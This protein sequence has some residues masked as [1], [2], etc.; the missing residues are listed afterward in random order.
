MWFCQILNLEYLNVIKKNFLVILLFNFFAA[1]LDAIL[2]F[3]FRKLTKGASMASVRYMLT[4]GCGVSLLTSNWHG[5]KFF[6]HTLTWHGP[7][8]V[9]R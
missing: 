4:L 1:I 5:D 2:Y 3:E 8:A 7:P 9:L 6:L